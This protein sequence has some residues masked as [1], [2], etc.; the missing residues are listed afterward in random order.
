VRVDIRTSSTHITNNFL[1]VALLPCSSCTSAAPLL[2]R[3]SYPN[4]PITAPP[5]PLSIFLK[6]LS[7]TSFYSLY[8]S[9]QAPSAT[10]PHSAITTFVEHLV[11]S[12]PYFKFSRL[13]FS[14]ILHLADEQLGCEVLTIFLSHYP[15][16]SP[17][18][19]RNLSSCLLLSLRAD[20]IELASTLLK[21]VSG[22]YLG[23][24]ID[25]LVSTTIKRHGKVKL[26]L[27]GSMMKVRLDEE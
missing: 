7:S 4:L 16:S 14:S 13:L 18:S 22:T 6:K 23:P 5:T 8:A 2:L 25:F 11:S 19:G 21:R 26:R 15:P 12:D 17:S 1:L 27:L 3:T 24:S 10:T 20:K 9:L